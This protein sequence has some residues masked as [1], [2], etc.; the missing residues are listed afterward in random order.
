MFRRE[1]EKAAAARLAA[2]RAAAKKAAAERLAAERVT[3]ERG[4]RLQPLSRRRRG[5]EPRRLR[6]VIGRSE[7]RSGGRWPMLSPEA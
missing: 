7:W 6:Q 5:A 2:Q 1:V 3:A 4:G